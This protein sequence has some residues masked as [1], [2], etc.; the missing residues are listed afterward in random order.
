MEGS[1]NSSHRDE[2]IVMSSSSRFASPEDSKNN[3]KSSTESLM[4]IISENK[5][6]A[7]LG[8]KPPETTKDGFVVALRTRDHSGFIVPFPVL[9][10]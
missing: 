5:L 8:R 9:C 10:Y 2:D 4:E 6:H 1:N 7:G 3:Q